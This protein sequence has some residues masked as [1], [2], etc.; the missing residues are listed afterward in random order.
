MIGQLDV[1]VYYN[2]ISKKWEVHYKDQPKQ[3]FATIVDMLTFLGK[4]ALLLQN[5]S[6][7][8]FKAQTEELQRLFS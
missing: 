6:E 2:T 8:Q 4:K 3:D 5:E 7:F 1:L